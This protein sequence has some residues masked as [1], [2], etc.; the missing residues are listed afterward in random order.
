M[1]SSQSSLHLSL[2]WDQDLKVV[3]VVVVVVVAGVLK[4]CC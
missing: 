3:V 2:I 4:S 1:Y